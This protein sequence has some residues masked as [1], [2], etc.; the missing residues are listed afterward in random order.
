[1]LLWTWLGTRLTPD[2]PSPTCQGYG[3]ADN[4]VVYEKGDDGGNQYR[5]NRITQHTLKHNISMLEHLFT[6]LNGPLTKLWKNDTFPPNSFE[7]TV[8]T[9]DPIVIREITSE[10]TCID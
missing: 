7:L 10:K 3:Y 6:I 8:T 1:M 9:T 5:C 4:N 2:G